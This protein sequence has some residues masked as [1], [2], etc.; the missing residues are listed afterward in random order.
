MDRKTDTKDLPNDLSLAGDVWMIIGPVDC[1]QLV[2]R[3]LGAKNHP[4]LARSTKLS[5]T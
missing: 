5:S 3:M 1:Y 4:Y 2:L